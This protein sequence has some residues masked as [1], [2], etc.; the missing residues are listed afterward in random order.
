M[1]TA[2]ALAAFTSTSQATLYT[3]TTGDLNNGVPSGDNLSGF[4]HLDITSVEVTNDCSQLI[5][6]INVAGNPV[7]TDWGK[8]CI[9]FDS[10]AGGDT[11]GNGWGRPIALTQGMDYWVGTWVDGGMGAENRKWNGATWDLQSATY[12]ANP[13]N[14]SISK[15][16]SNVTIKVSFVGLGKLPGDSID[17]D[18]Y[19]T[20]GGGTDSA[21]DSLANPN[22]AVTA[23]AGPYATNLF[24]TYTI[25]SVPG[26]DTTNLV[27]FTVNMEIPI[28]E[29]DNAIGDGFNTNT[30]QLFV[31][32][33]FNGFTN[34]PA[35]QLIQVGTSTVF[36]NTVEVVGP[37]GAVPEYKLYGFSFP[38]YENPV[39]SCGN[40]RS[41]VI[42]NQNITIPAFYWSDRKLSDPTNVVNLNVDMSLVRNF[43]KF[44]PSTNGVAL[45]GSFNGWN[46]GSL[47]LTAGSPPDTN[48]YSASI[49]YRHYPT[50]GCAFGFYK[51]YISNLVDPN[52]DN[53]WEQPITTGGGNRSFGFPSTS[54][55]L[56]YYY[57]DEKPTFKI[58]SVQKLDADSAAVTFESFP[59]RGGLPGY[60][61]GGV[62]MVESS[63]LVT[64]GVWTSNGTVV[65]TTSSSTFT[66][67]GLTGTNQLFYKVSLIGL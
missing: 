48:I 27:K 20:A 24:R 35:Y 10:T 9:G 36:T 5:F 14:L 51:F 52:R 67:T 37:L 50:N 38:G 6:T 30:D 59:K 60:P 63:P 19:A 43:G 58:T 46:T 13:D 28:W 57:N 12:A 61:T 49:S 21:I 1:A 4:T 34:N 62:Y 44:D 65:S 47:P 3:D 33:T 41:F 29:Y 25:T 42:T 53:G 54:Q 17:F 23:W 40:N 8:Y 2:V 39:L 45:P 22:I 16:T 7:T 26:C 55:T 66:N 32:G 11:A 64:G 18:V 15:T 56:S 31:R